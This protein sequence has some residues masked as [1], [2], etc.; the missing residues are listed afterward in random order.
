MSGRKE[1]KA[2]TTKAEAQTQ[3]T[4]VVAESSTEEPNPKPEQLKE[5][6]PESVPS[7]P[8]KDKKERE[9]KGKGKEESL[10][11]EDDGT[12]IELLDKDKKAYKVLK[13]GA[14]LS[15]VVKNAL[16]KDPTATQIPTTHITAEV[17]EKIV[18]WM[19]YHAKVPPPK[20]AEPIPS[21]DLKECGIDEFDVKLVD[22]TKLMVFEIILG[23]RE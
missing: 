9:S 23:T 6:K 15:T 13:K 17:M 12:E 22:D 11:D 4:Q 1:K 19:I 14:L 5:P 10:D 21:N 7:S 3:K 16:D 18:A 2:K 20:I 8:L